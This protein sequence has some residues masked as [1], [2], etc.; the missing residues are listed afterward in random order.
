MSLEKLKNDIEKLDKTQQLNVFN[1]LKNAKVSY[2]ENNNG[3]FI[4]IS[5]LK[6]QTIDKIVDFLLYIKE[7][8]IILDATEKLKKTYKDKYFTNS[9][10]E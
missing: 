1:I 6:Q 3:I 5:E 8:K 10:A 2:S 4:N 7:Q 9:N